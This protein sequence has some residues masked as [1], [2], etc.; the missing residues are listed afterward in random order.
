[1]PAPPLSHRGRTAPA[2]PIRR[3]H[4]HAEAARRR[5]LH[6]HQLNIG[7]P[8]LA[9]SSTMLAAYR[10]FDAK[11]VGYSPS[12]GTEALRAAWAAYYNDLVVPAELP[13]ITS[14]EVLITVGGSEALLFLISAVCDVGDAIVV[15][16]PYYTNYRGFAHMLG[17]EVVAVSAF[18][19]EGFAIPPERVVE[20]LHPRCRALV[21]PT[22]GN[23]TGAVLSAAD[24]RALAKVCADHDMFLISDEVYREFVYDG[25]HTV[26]P[27]AL[28]LVDDFDRVA[29]VDSVSKRYSACGA[30][31]GCIVTRNAELY[32]AAL[33]FAQA[34]L[35][36]PTVDQH[37]ALAALATPAEEMRHAIEEYGRRR[38]V[39]VEG[40]NAIEGVSCT[41]PAGAFYMIAELPVDD[42]QAFCIFLLEEFELDGETLMLAPAGGF[43][44]REGAGI[45]QVRVAYVLGVEPLK[46]CLKILRAALIAWHARS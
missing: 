5:G 1:M 18:A 14:D 8:D 41:T 30:R 27:S 37:A 38:D 22:P 7:Q 3:L 32:A 13:S 24:L 40:L 35:S 29:V 43:Y 17:V 33:K 36:P 39:L 31:I 6:V 11:V 4:P 44:A 16:E 15:A 21:V 9:T 46:R 19:S 10:S 12:Q 26:A 20:A 45:N 25:S 28:A 2:S 23:P 42:A 34:R